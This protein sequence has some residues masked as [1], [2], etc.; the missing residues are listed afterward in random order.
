MPQILTINQ[1]DY[2]IRTSFN[3]WTYS[4]Y[5]PVFKAFNAP[6]I[7]RLSIAST[8]PIDVLNQCSIEQIS[9][10]AEAM[11]YVEQHNI[12][13]AL[14]TKYELIEVGAQSWS[15]LEQ[16]KQA[17][18]KSD[19]INA[20]PDVVKIYT[21]EEIADRPLLDVWFYSSF[22]IQSLNKFF[23]QFAELNESKATSR[24][25]AAGIEEIQSLGHFPSVIKI[26]RERGMTNEEVLQLPAHGIYLEFVYDLRRRKF[27]EKLTELSKRFDK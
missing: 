19:L 3:E 10:L 11:Q 2:S 8:I 14:C 17:I 23:S 5:I 9:I 25:E 4:D 20:M 24:E 26:A 1:V 18:A 6:F 27:E 22:Y 16:A 12:L 13:D 15:K 7:D 21:G